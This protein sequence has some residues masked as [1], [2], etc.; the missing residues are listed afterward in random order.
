MSSLPLL[1]V[2]LI[3]GALAWPFAIGATVVLWSR[4]RARRREAA[5]ANVE[6]GVRQLYSTLEAQ[7]IPPR[8]AVTVDAMQEA[9]EMALFKAAVRRHRRQLATS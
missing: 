7:P 1:T 3:V 5:L 9:E 6:A 4:A 8:L 2:L